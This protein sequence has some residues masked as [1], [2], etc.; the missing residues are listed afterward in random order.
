VAIS[1]GARQSGDER[2][3]FAAE[4]GR[5]G[6]TYFP[7]FADDRDVAEGIVWPKASLSELAG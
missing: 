3:S 2:R 4:T 5:A 6:G 1:A 7:P